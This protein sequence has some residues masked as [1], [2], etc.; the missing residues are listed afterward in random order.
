M[1]AIQ[2]A[3][4]ANANGVQLLRIRKDAPG[5]YDVKDAFCGRKTGWFYL[6]S[7]TASAIAQIYAA[8]NETNRAKLDK[9]PIERLADIAFRACGR[10]A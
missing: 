9:L 1:T 3:Q 7:F 8:V 5:Q 10:S 2:A 6:D 4:H